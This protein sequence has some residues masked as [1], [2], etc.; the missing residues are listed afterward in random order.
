MIQDRLLERIPV[1]TGDI[2][3]FQGENGP[4]E[5]LSLGDYGKDVNL[6][7]HRKVE[8]TALLPLQEKWVLTISS[9]YGC[10][11]GCR[12]CS[13]PKVGPGLNCSTQDMLD[14]IELGI[15]LHPE[16]LPTKRLNI[17]FARMGEPTFNPLVMN[18]A[19]YAKELYHTSLVHPVISTMMPKANTDLAR[20]LD[21]WVSIK[22]QNFFGDAG[23][24]LSINSTDNDERD[25]I[26]NGNAH[27][28]EDIS[29]IMCGVLHSP[30]NRGI[31]LGRK[32]TLNFIVAD[33]TVDPDKLAKWFDPKYFIIKLTPMHKTP[34]AEAAGL[35]TPGDY[36]DYYPYLPLEQKFKEAGY[37]VLTFI[38]SKEEDESMITC[39]NA[40]LAQRKT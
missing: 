28:L 5:C 19:L 25:F 29:L 37:D 32:I 23:L 14:Q 38:A 13:V 11:M 36:T 15:S 17:H 35:R 27:R 9:Q 33:W 34:E 18:V 4:L 1:P 24:Q 10:S 21:L 16:C 20:Y 8:H 6:N 2:L 3:L 12:F 22:N 31:L 7:Q 30:S 40:V 39:G 26:F